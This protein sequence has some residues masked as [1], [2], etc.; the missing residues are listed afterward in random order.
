MKAAAAA[1]PA[2]GAAP[3]P[4]VAPGAARVASAVLS[5]LLVA[6]AAG[7]AIA[8][9]VPTMAAWGL[10]LQRFLAPGIAWTTWGIA[11]LALVPAIGARLAPALAALG[12]R[13]GRRGGASG[14][15]LAAALVVASC[16][17]RVWFV[18]DY[19]MRYAT[20]QYQHD[21][22][23]MFPQTMP[24]DTLLHH[25]LPMML[26]SATGLPVLTYARVLG[27]LEAGG[28][29]W[30]AARFAVAA[31]FRGAAATA[32]TALIA[33]GGALTT[34]TGYL[35]PAAELCL[36]TAAVGAQGL[37]LARTGRRAPA[38]GI[39][40]AVALAM[41][42]SALA[43][44]P[45]GAAAWAIAGLRHPA[46]RR[47]AS[48]WAGAALPLATLAM[49]LPRLVRIVTTFDLPHHL[50]T[51]EVR[52]AG[53]PLAAALAGLRALDL[54]NALVVLCPLAI[55]L[56]VLVA[57]LGRRALRSPEALVLAAL[58]VPQAAIF[59]LVHP[60]QGVFRDW[61]VLAPAGVAI[62]LALAWWSG[63]VLAARPGRGAL[64]AAISVSVALAA[65]QWLLHGRDRERGLERVRA[66][67]FEA[68]MHAD[69]ER[70][71]ALDFL[72]NRE[73][74]LGHWGGAAD[75]FGEAVTLEPSPRLL[76]SWAMALTQS[77]DLPGALRAYRQLAQRA[78]DQAPGWA[79]LAVTA[80]R[81][82]E[83]DEAL[84]AARALDRLRAGNPI[85]REVATFWARAD[86]DSAAARRAR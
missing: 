82:G 59:V 65:L 84:E 27:V 58:V 25:T 22:A 66:F 16:P 36:L 41:H 24:L 31:G 57:T 12:D 39:T 37:E 56:P 43:L 77:G 71:S 34:F 40:L 46:L 63:L 80:T 52:A 1:P 28:F 60:Q 20:L 10:N 44:L 75:V 4:A 64:A 70:A 47:R 5:A 32:V 69:A 49:L 81:L 83:R 50:A 79:G 13:L 72:G 53:G 9:F 48:F 7:R 55:A 14:I 8:T 29:A 51:P 73:A 19:L 76:Q 3:P 67:A 18:G 86:S 68:P 38:L 74:E 23:T 35:R 17:D 54:A 30:C 6:L 15:A 11:A 45:A 62:A 85:V 21:F 26:R 2:A 33:C 42:R 78:P 61:D